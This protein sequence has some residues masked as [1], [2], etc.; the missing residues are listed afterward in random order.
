MNKYLEMAS[1]AITP[2]IWAPK[3][4][5]S[6]LNLLGVGDVA[7]G[8]TGNKGFYGNLTPTQRKYAFSQMGKGIG[9]GV[10]IMAVAALNGWEV[11]Y[12]PESVTFGSIKKNGKAYNVFGRF[13]NVAKTITQLVSGRRK[14]EKEVQDLD[15]KGGRKNVLFKFFRGKM[16]PFAGVIYD[17]VLNN[18]KNSFTY[19]PITLKSLPNELLTPISVSEIKKGME[20]DGTISLLTRFLPAFE[21]IQVSDDRDFKDKK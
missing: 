12:N 7:Y 16:T 21:G 1:P 15:E 17:Y 11:D 20:Q 6:S 2:F 14:L 18:K 13:S 10:A 4:L 3:M 5:A 19:E 9:M 8:L